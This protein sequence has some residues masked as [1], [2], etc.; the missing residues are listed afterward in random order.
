MASGE[1]DKAVILA[2]GLG[3]RMQ[4]ADDEARLDSKQAKAAQAGLKAL[5]PVGRPFLDYVLTG[6][7]DA[8]YRRVCLV[9]GPGHDAVRAY[10]GQ[11]V[12]CRRLEITFAVQAEPKGTADAV[13]AAEEFA[14]GNP[15]LVINADNYY[16]P[17]TLEALRYLGENGLIGFDREGLLE[18]SNIPP[19]RIARFAILETDGDGYLT[20]IV[21]K[22]SPE[23]VAR[24]R[25]PICVSM[26]SWR[27]D[28]RMFAAL[29]AIKPS[30]R[31]ELEIPDAVQLATDAMGIR[32]RSVPF[33]APVL[34]LTDRSDVA[35]VSG[36]VQ[37]ME[38]DL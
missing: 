17:E 25:E 16:P 7:A 26:N 27:F 36:L 13:C 11:E 3:T 33:S 8:G 23:Q 24:L 14:N 18:G 38:V 15:F 32:F 21:E 6:V 2:A 28:E 34:D 10:Y 4:E 37:E 9:I 20:R 29:R 35:A 22:P 31:G 1:T 5:M 30:P 12:T 19:D